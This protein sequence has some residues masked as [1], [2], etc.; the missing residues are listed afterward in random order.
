[1][2]DLNDMYI[3]FGAKTECSMGMRE[4]KLVLQKDHGI[5][6]RDKAQLNVKDNKA[7]DNV[8]PFGGCKSC[9][10]P[11]TQKNM[12]AQG[13][14]APPSTG[15]LYAIPQAPVTCAGMCKPVITSPEWE[16]GNEYTDVDDEKALLGRCTLTCAYGGVIKITDSGQG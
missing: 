14:T 2:P 3:V 7:N 15:P 12:A 10:N 1:M 9:G 11:D 13:V 16:N 8:I 5:F 6:I 4:S